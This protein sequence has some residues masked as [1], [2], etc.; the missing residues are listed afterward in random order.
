MKTKILKKSASIL[1]AAF[2]PCLP[3]AEP[4]AKTSVKEE[5]VYKVNYADGKEGWRG[6]EGYGNSSQPLLI[7]EDPNDRAKSVL[8]IVTD[9]SQ[10]CGF[11]FRVPTDLEIETDYKLTFR[12]RTASAIKLSA[13][14]TDTTFTQFGEDVKAWFKIP[15][16]LVNEWIDVEYL[17]R[18]I[19]PSIGLEVAIENEQY[20]PFELFIADFTISKQR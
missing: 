2:V 16:N 5:I 19:D 1:L 10:G 12:I 8:K 9:G 15:R 13:R 11:Q 7:V 6:R 4:D 14:I 20:E 17:F 3:A 18:P